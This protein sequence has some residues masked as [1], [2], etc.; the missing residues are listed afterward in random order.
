M[1]S[2]DLYVYNPN[3]KNYHYTILNFKKYCYKFKY[4][5]YL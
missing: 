3:A 4:N 5:K 2:E 1:T